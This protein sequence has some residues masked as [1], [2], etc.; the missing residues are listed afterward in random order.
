M[1]LDQL[2]YF[3]ETA[4]FEHLGKASKALHIC[5]SAISHSIQM[6][7]EE[8]D[9]ELFENHGKHIRLTSQGQKMA[10]H[11]ESVIGKLREIKEQMTSADPALWNG[12]YRL[13]VTP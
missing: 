10:K 8:L 4:K 5:P 9:C 6:L 12:T 11:A 3:F 7:E 13:A 2:V 1:K